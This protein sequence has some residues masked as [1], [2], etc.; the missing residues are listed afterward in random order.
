MKILWYVNIVMPAA[1]HALGKGGVNVGGWLTGAMEALRDTG[2]ELSVLTVS[3]LVQKSM[4]FCIDDV[5]Y[6]LIPS[7]NFA[8]EFEKIILQEDIDLV[9]I[10]GTEY[11]YNTKMIHLCVDKKF[12]HVVSLQGIMY[13]YAKYYDAGLPEKFR[14]V[15]LLRKWMRKLY[16]ADSIAL[17]KVRFD[18]QGVR[19]IIALQQ[20]QAVIG[21]TDW[22]KKSALA[23]NPELKY[24]HVNENLR[25]VFYEGEGWLL[26]NCRRHTLFISQSAYPI[27]G[28]HMLLEAMPELIRRYP[29]LQVVVGGQKPYTLNNALLDL[30]VDY[31]FEYQ[32]YIKQLIR[33]YDLRD[34]IHYTGSLN[35]EE[36]KKQFLMCNVFLSCSSIENSPNSVGE[37]MMLGVPVVASN[38][39]GTETMLVDG[40][41]GILYDFY[42]RQ[43]MVDAISALFD[44][45]DLAIKV[46][47]S[48]RHH[49]F[50][51]HDR[52]KNTQDLLM[53]YRSIK[54]EN[55]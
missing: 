6:L 8:S 29:D 31:F 45:D 22:D 53:V 52:E 16:Y 1:A 2:I 10:F 50:L 17:E 51:T 48:A 28:F 33:K 46:S 15:N 55:V 43:A 37:A 26:E 40:E 7:K 11:E 49:A 25:D 36:M 4:Q 18:E 3:G 41:D 47:A 19:E 12:P 34:R 38:V 9:H 5:T 30:G 21:R 20:A 27:K 23:V 54:E 24:Y 13:Q 32:S 44:Q 42:D 39:G 14:K 35:A